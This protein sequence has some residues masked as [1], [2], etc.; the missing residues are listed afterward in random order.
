MVSIST[1]ARYIVQKLDYS[2]VVGFKNYKSG[3]ITDAQLGDVIWKNLFQGKLTYLHW[4]KGEE[5]ASGLGSLVGTLLVRRI[6]HATP[7][8]VFVGDV[9]VLKDPER[10][11][12]FLVR[13]LAATEGYEMVSTDEKE[14]PFILKRDQCW[15]LADDKKLKPKKLVLLIMPGSKGQSNIWASINGW[16]SRQSYLLPEDSCG[17]WTSEKQS[18]WHD[19]GFAHFRS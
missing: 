9:V 8:R 13:R 4:N 17:P 7:Q 6:P 18:L 16:Y 14:Q 2:V 11:E 5:M 19:E 15:V 1:W 12:D 3:H 10:T